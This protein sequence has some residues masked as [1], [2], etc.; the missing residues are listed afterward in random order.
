MIKYIYSA[1]KRLWQITPQYPSRGQAAFIVGISNSLSRTP[2]GTVKA[3]NNTKAVAEKCAELY[4]QG[5]SRRI[6]FSGCF[7]EREFGVSEKSEM[8]R[9]ALEGGVE[10]DNI[11]LESTLPPSHGTLY[12]PVPVL[13]DIEKDP[14]A[15]KEAQDLGVIIVFHPL[16]SRRGAAIFKHW[17]SKAGTSFYPVLSD[18]TV[19]ESGKAATQPWF[20]YGERFYFFY[21]IGMYMDFKLTRGLLSRIVAKFRPPLR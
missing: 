21:E 14:K 3:S 12:Q 18:F 17:F 11:L 16:Q 20:K 4:Q 6:L 8:R 1:A 15:F 7:G 19:N 5:W 2:D 9:I 13:K 10:E